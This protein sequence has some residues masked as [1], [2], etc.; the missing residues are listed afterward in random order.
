M[1]TVPHRGEL[2]KEAINHSAY[3]I[4]KVAEII[5]KSNSTIHRWFGVPNLP[6]KDIILVSEKCPRINLRHVFEALEQELGEELPDNPYRK[7]PANQMMV[8][9]DGIS[10]SIDSK[11]FSGYK[12][13]PNLNQLVVDLIEKYQTQDTD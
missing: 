6:L 12:I 11:R 13:P 3:T 4:K 5:G 7:G 9:D 8:Q 1:A 2:L 10:I